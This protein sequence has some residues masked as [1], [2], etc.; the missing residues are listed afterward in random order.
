M[1]FSKAP[2]HNLKHESRGASGL[3]APKEDRS[4]SANATSLEDRLAPSAE[5]RL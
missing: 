5:E 3:D 1:G 4:A 2:N